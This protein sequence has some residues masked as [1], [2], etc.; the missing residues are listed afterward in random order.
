MTLK[1]FAWPLN[2]VVNNFLQLS[3]SAYFSASFLAFKAI[4]GLA[5]H[6]LTDLINVKQQFGRMMLRSQSELQLFPPRTITKKTL[7]DRS[8]TASAPKLWNK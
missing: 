2:A 8:F 6:Y 7:G 5:P 1:T 4:N 3:F